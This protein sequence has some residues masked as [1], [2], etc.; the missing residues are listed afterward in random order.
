MQVSQAPKLLARL[1]FSPFA[2]ATKG[3]KEVACLLEK[4]SAMPCN[5]S[6]G[7]GELMATLNILELELLT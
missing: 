2:T 3:T 6:Q 7:T 4:S 5:F 1:E